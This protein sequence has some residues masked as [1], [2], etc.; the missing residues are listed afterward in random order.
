[1]GEVEGQASICDSTCFFLPVGAIGCAL[2]PPA[3]VTRIRYE[4]SNSDWVSLNV[5]GVNIGEVCLSLSPVGDPLQQVPVATGRGEVPVA[6]RGER[7]AVEGRV[8]ITSR[9]GGGSTSAYFQDAR[10]ICQEDVG[11]SLLNFNELFP[12]TECAQTFLRFLGQFAGSGISEVINSTGPT[13]N[14]LARLLDGKQFFVDAMR[15]PLISYL[16]EYTQI[17]GSSL[18]IN[19]YVNPT[20]DVSAGN[21]LTATA[22]GGQLQFSGVNCEEEAFPLCFRTFPN[23]TDQINTVCADCSTEKF[24]CQKWVSLD[25]QTF[26]ASDSTKYFIT[27]AEI[28]LEPC[29]INGGVSTW[30]EAHMACQDMEN[31]TSTALVSLLGYDSFVSNNAEAKNFLDATKQ[32][33][34]RDI[35]M[36]DIGPIQGLLANIFS[37]NGIKENFHVKLNDSFCFQDSGSTKCG[38]LQGILEDGFSELSVLL[39]KVDNSNDPGCLSLSTPS[40]SFVSSS[41]STKLRPLCLRGDPIVQPEST[42]QRLKWKQQRRKDKKKLKRGKKSKPEPRNLEGRQA[43][44][45]PVFLDY[46]LAALPAVLIGGLLTPS[47]LAAAPI[48]P[49]P[50]PPPPPPAPTTP[51]QR[52]NDIQTFNRFMSEYGRVYPTAAETVFRQ[53][54]FLENLAVI[55]AQNLLF[56]SGLSSYFLRVNQYSDRTFAEFSASFLGLGLFNISGGVVPPRENVRGSLRQDIPAPDTLDLTNSGCITSIKN[57]LCNTCAAHATTA[58]VEYCLCAAS[59]QLPSSRS[60]QQI[61]ECTDGRG[62]DI[63]TSLERVNTHCVSGF[64]D[65]HLDFVIKELNGNIEAETNNPESETNK[66]CNRFSRDFTS[67]RV[68]DYVSDIFTDEDH[69]VDAVSQIG[70]TATNIAVTPKIQHYGGGV[71]YNPDECQDYEE[72]EVPAECV[73]ERSG[74]LS[75]TCLERNGVNCAE[76]LPKHCNI[77]FVPSEVSY[78][79][80]LTATGYGQDSEGNMFWTMKNS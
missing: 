55:T 57:Q 19:Q 51:P 58:A 7:R 21:C 23:L 68:V 18:N 42:P 33:D 75:Y 14:E 8:Q 11:G 65:V 30:A 37:A 43:V 78:P 63:G 3:T 44:T 72:E 60:V 25:D 5:L 49:N 29:N 59:G 80:S 31:P 39:T 35:V 56:T 74:R 76:L 9:Q 24:N 22:S 46:C 54:V 62:L 38:Y 67:A 73:E 52:L 32:S 48:V 69:L 64:P 50:P 45:P 10:K 79:H 71:Y 53:A 77:F 41:C 20:G 6:T 26:I 4:C 34:F 1:V 40:H 13:Q 15:Q 16:Y 28:C 2:A 36:T 66:G 12:S 61:S 47:A 27:N 17:E 70:P